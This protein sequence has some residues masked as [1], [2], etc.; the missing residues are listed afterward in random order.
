MTWPEGTG[1]MA[2]MIRTFDWTAT[3]LGPVE[4]W[5]R[6]LRQTIELIL[7][8]PLPMALF[9]GPEHIH[10]YNDDYARLLQYKHPA[11][12]GQPLHA[13]WPEVEHFNRQVFA[14]VFQGES[15]LQKDELYPSDAETGAL[16]HNWF[17][18]A[19]SPARDDDGHVAGVLVTVMNV[20]RQVSAEHLLRDAEERQAF[21]LRLSDALRPLSDPA[22]VQK[23]AT[24]MMNQ[25]FGAT[26]SAYLELG[27]D[28][29]LVTTVEGQK[30]G[31]TRMPRQFRISDFSAWSAEAFAQGRG[32]PIDD[33]DQ[34]PRLSDAARA[35]F[36]A[37]GM[38][39][40]AGVPLCKGGRPVAAVG[41]GL[42]S[43]H[44]WTRSDLYLLEEVAKRTWEALE[45]ARA[46]TDLRQSEQRLQLALDATSM[47]TFVWN[48]QTN[49]IDYDARAKDLLGQPQWPTVNLGAFLTEL[50]HPDDRD[51]FAQGSKR[52]LAPDSDGQFWEEFRTRLPDGRIRW[53]AVASR[54]VSQEGGPPT[55]VVG[56][57]RDVT[58]TREVQDAIQASEERLRILV[59]EL[60]HRV[61]NILTVVR[62]V[63]SRTVE[64]GGEAQ[65][66]ADHFR[67]R[68]DALAR[69]QVVMT[70][71]AAGTADL[72]NLIRD[73]LMSVGVHD[74]VNV[75]IEGPDVLLS[76]RIA[77]SLG[78]AIHEL[79]TNALKYGALKIEG[80]KLDIRWTVSHE[81]DRPLRL[82]FT[83]QEQ[84]VP[85]ISLSPAREGFGRELIEEA[86]PYRLGAE[87]RLEFRGGG[88][89]CTLSVPLDVVDAGLP[90]LDRMLSNEQP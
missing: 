55:H 80:A 73:E 52:M 38:R 76:S 31:S 58:V 21:L 25:R 14:R 28:G 77:E 64:A 81:P 40:A 1:E 50:I 49:A 82:E 84:G 2:E 51:R 85:A 67:G 17:L 23:T 36:R 87:T 56:T 34:D 43:P 8:H 68:L 37:M 18:L 30:A 71:T 45:R 57:V 61:R 60:Q 89:R 3:S 63:F 74:G 88:L 83:W 90:P 72:E 13:I 6:N 27:P 39:A 78:L 33:I 75:R 10:L 22:A 53:L 19:Y 32:V 69:T 70:Q 41:I 47:G 86:L 46:E 9:W 59:A 7:A 29:D 66:V 16:Q 48:L 54:A 26:R 12:L 11:S 42:A 44:K 79:T 35:T 5:P 65:D 62:S 20:T 24:L 15:I 4:S